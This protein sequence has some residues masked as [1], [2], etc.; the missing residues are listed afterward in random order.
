MNGSVVSASLTSAMFT[1]LAARDPKEAARRLRPVTALVQGDASATLGHAFDAAHGLLRRGY[2]S[3]YFY[4]NIVVSKIVFGR[5]S[6]RTASALLELPVGRSIAD[7][8]VLNGTSTV[9]EI[10]TDLD[11]FARLTSQLTDYL[12]CFEH[13]N[14]VTS[15]AKVSAAAE[16]APQSVGI[17]G[18]QPN[19]SL[20]RIRASEGG[21]SSIKPDR[22]FELLRQREAL[23][24]LDRA[25]GY[26]QDVPPGDL[27]ARCKALFMT[28]PIDVSHRE[29]ISALRMRGM[30]GANLASEASFPKSLR[31]LAYETELSVIG[32]TR[33]RSRLAAPAALLGV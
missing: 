12:A 28:L 19:G 8:V 16:A 6:P 25:L 4:K 32:R 14:V 7:V 26:Q 27:W 9:Y 1:A 3:E 18:L 2:R 31:A 20:S 21:L 11:S 17:I 33:M 22:L 10:K 29:S 23:D 30:H 5:H 15:M 13:V 24:V